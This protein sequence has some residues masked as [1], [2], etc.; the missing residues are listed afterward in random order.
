MKEALVVYILQGRKCIRSTSEILDGTFGFGFWP[1]LFRALSATRPLQLLHRTLCR[2]SASP[3]WFSFT[4]H[5]T[6]IP[7]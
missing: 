4:S 3:I 6:S 7:V 2:P 5:L 1:F